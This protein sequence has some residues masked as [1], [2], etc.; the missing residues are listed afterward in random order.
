MMTT[1]VK[2]IRQKIERRTRDE[3]SRDEGL[4]CLR[5]GVGKSIHYFAFSLKYFFQENDPSRVEGEP[6]LC[7]EMLVDGFEFKNSWKSRSVV[8]SEATGKGTFAT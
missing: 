1:E 5:V 2:T 6:V 4:G 8:D 3:L 7:L